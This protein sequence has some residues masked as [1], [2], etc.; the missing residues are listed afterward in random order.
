MFIFPVKLIHALI[1]AIKKDE[2]TV[3]QEWT[4]LIKQNDFK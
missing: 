4:E 3:D 1:S 2:T